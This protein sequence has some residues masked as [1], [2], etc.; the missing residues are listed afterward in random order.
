MLPI[1][2][3]VFA[4]PYLINKYQQYKSGQIGHTGS[5]GTTDLGISEDLGK[6]INAPTTPQ[7][8]SN[9]VNGDNSTGKYV[10]NP[11]KA[12]AG[13][14]L[15]AVSNAWSN[16]NGSKVQNNAQTNPSPA[17]SQNTGKKDMNE[18]VEINGVRKTR[19]SAMQEGLADENGN[20]YTTDYLTERANREAAERQAREE[21]TRG[22]INTAFDAIEG[23]YS[24]ILTD[25]QDREKA[26]VEGA[27]KTAEVA[28]KGISDARDSANALLENNVTQVGERA[29]RATQKVADN[30]SQMQIA[31][32]MQLGSIGAGDSSATNVMAPFAYQKLAGKNQGEI[33][34]QANDQY[35]DIDNKKVEVKTTYD[36]MITDLD[37]SILDS[38]EGIRQTYGGQISQVKQA[39]ASAKG[40]R[41]KALAAL[42][43]QLMSEAASK[44]QMLD[45]FRMTQTAQID[46]WARN[47]IAQLDNYKI[48]AAAK[49]K[50]LKFDPRE[51]VASEMSAPNIGL[52]QSVETYMNPQMLAA[53]RKQLGYDSVI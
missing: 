40:E 29:K 34:M 35:A 19:Q 26:A 9:I 22:E 31:T 43:S 10:V 30:L 32:S 13:S 16:V 49:G 17:P 6:I 28:K 2:L 52:P 46:D 4:S 48:E 41:A 20:L 38:L 44:L 36:K 50:T 47:R 18:V 24:N 5:A 42:S 37:T 45:Q 51:I 12:V 33:Q 14:V 53:R 25:W 7:G 1:S 11:A 27:Q 21:Q 39:L 23:G 15:G 8:G 3:G